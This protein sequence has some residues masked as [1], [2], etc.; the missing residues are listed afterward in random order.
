MNFIENR[1]D[2]IAEC[3]EKRLRLHEFMRQHRLDAVLVSRHENIA[4]LTAGAV[5][6]R[7]GLLRETGP[8]SLLVTKDGQSFYITT[9]NEAARLADEEFASLSY[10]PLLRAWTSN[11]V[12][13]SI[14]VALP[15]GRIGT[16]VPL[17][18]HKLV[19]LQTLRFQLTVGEIARYHWL[20]AQTSEAITRV[21]LSIVPGMSERA[22]QAA[23]AHEAVRGERKNRA[24]T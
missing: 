1:D 3:A 15:D 16:D 23:V 9:N 5:D 13:A 24:G 11:D 12:E 7:V 4:W 10:R 14:R 8:A 19:N 22:M 2:V 18:D 21:L 6:V 17:G 20:G